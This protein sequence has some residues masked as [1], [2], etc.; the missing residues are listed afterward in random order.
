MQFFFVLEGL[1][2][3]VS[4]SLNG[5]NKDVQQ[6]YPAL[7]LLS[8]LFLHYLSNILITNWFSVFRTRFHKKFRSFSITKSFTFRCKCS[9]LKSLDSTKALVL[10]N[11]K[12]KISGKRVLAFQDQ[13][14]PEIPKI[15]S[16]W[17]YVIVFVQALC[18][19]MALFYAWILD[20]NDRE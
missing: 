9:A 15:N 7:A 6:N 3:I 8:H 2:K 13:T 18:K 19:K 4:N 16:R 14:W 11:R 1:A 10:F 12:I 17:V 20:V 5:L